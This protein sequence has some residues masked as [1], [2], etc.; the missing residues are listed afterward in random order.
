M[1]LSAKVAQ[2]SGDKPTALA[3]AQAALGLADDRAACLLASLEIEA[4]D[5]ANNRLKHH[6]QAILGQ[7]YETLAI[8]LIIGQALQ[9]SFPH[10]VPLA[11]LGMLEAH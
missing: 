9:L 7:S 10:D 2:A 11:T 8:K 6:Y 3:L 1:Y 4:G 5:I